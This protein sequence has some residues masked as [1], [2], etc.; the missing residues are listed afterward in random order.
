MKKNERAAVASLGASNHS[1][2]EREINDY[3][4][5]SPNSVV[6]LLDKLKEYGIMLHD[7][8]VIEPAVGDGAI[9]RKLSEVRFNKFVCYDVV[10]RK[11]P[12]T[13]LQDFLTVESLNISEPKAIITNPPY[14]LA[15]EFVEHSMGLLDEGEYCIMLLKIQFLESQSR[16]PLFDKYPPKHIWVFSERQKCLKNGVDDGTSSAMCYAWYVFQKGF[17]GKPQLDW[18]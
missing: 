18:I 15:P 16:R 11:F 4:A 17:K 1:L 9:I 7:K 3:Y 2:K 10:D 5:T 8:V 13:I 12:H 6:G 14:K